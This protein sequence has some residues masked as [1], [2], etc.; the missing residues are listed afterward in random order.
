MS[1]IVAAAWDALDPDNKAAYKKR[2]ELAKKEYLRALAAYRANMVSKVRFIG[3][4]HTVQDLL[5][6]DTSIQDLYFNISEMKLSITSLYIIP[7][8]PKYDIIWTEN[9]DVFDSFIAEIL[10]YN[11]SSQIKTTKILKYVIELTI[12]YIFC[13]LNV[14]LMSLLL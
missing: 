3:V 6:Q 13:I 7:D 10:K 14:L 8:A 12:N 11:S 9:S 1:K 4:N 5:H 2:T